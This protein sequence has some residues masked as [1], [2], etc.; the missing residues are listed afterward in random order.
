MLAMALSLLP[1]ALLPHWA[2][3]GVGFIG[4]SV[5]FSI[6]GPTISVFSQQLVA[7]RWRA[8]MMG[9]AGL[10]MGLGYGGAALAGGYVIASLGYVALFLCGALSMLGS[11]VALWSYFRVPR[12]ELARSG[13]GAVA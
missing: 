10:T 6:T 8:L 5:L 13:A 11:A 7:P 2:A 3:A 1:V 4:M 9:I 12:G